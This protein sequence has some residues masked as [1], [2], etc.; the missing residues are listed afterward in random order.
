MQPP[1]HKEI[2]FIGGPVNGVKRVIDLTD[3]KNEIL[4]YAKPTL[5][6]SIE[7]NCIYK[8]NGNIANFSHDNKN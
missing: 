3:I 4:V 7:C 8:L 1:N 2:S 5:I 6:N